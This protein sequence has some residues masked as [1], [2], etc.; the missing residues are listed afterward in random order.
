MK[1]PFQPLLIVLASTLLCITALWHIQHRLPSPPLQTQLKTRYFG[2][3][4]VAK[5]E[6]AV[7]G[8]SL[9]FVNSRE[10]VLQE[11][12]KQIAAQGSAVAIIDSTQA[13]RELSASCKHFLDGTALAE[14]MQQLADWAEIQ[15]SEKRI[16]GGIGDGAML[17][18]LASQTYTSKNTDYL[19]IDF[20]VNVPHKLKVCPPFDIDQAT[21]T[22]K[23]SPDKPSRNH[24]R[25]VWT[26]QP[27][28]ETAVFVRSLPTADTVIAPYDTPL[29]QV[30]LDEINTLLGQSHS[31]APPMPTVEVL[32]SKPQSPLTLF[33]SGEG[34]W[35]GLDRSVAK[36][37][38]KSSFPVV[39]IDTL[40]YFWKHKTA[41]QAA[42]D[43][44]TTLAYYRNTQGSKT[45]ALMGYAFG[46]DI[47]PAIYNHL[48]SADKNAIKQLVL[49]APGEQ[50]NFEIHVSGWLGKHDGEAPL[51]PELAR[52]PAS[53]I[54]C[55][56]GKEA[57]H[58]GCNSLENT[59]AE[60]LELPGGQHFAQ[61]Y[62]NLA[63][64][65]VDVYR[66]HAWE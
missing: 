24:W 41:E 21:R 38:A 62:A 34:G 1:L 44:S 42:L 37:M 52:I 66:R 23:F 59:S 10:F 7:T 60:L 18:F 19:S 30:A 65:I 28:A 40:R 17:A 4:V 26:D 57:A 58:S 51:A 45:F 31:S 54:V 47:L 46:A 5:P 35:R 22:L 50:T 2:D 36:E 20:S 56:Y 48:P 53:K 27:P 14:P 9:L 11:L 12:A 63:Q 13:F 61:D 3:V 16:I 6:T 25:V 64:K 39:G 49:L 29:T 32:A 43:L 33:Y 8:L 55:V 15:G